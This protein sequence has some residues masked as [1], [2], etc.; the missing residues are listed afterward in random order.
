[1]V[2]SSLTFLCCALPLALAVY[3]LVP[4]RLKNGWLLL[5]SLAFYAWGEPLYVLLMLGSIAV[6]WALALRI[7]RTGGGK[8][9]FLMALAVVL[10]IGLLVVYK[11]SALLISSINAI[12]P[13]ALPVPQIRLPI[14]I[15]F[16]TF[17]ALSYVI[18]VYRGR[19]PVQPRI[20]KLALY[21]SLFPQLIAGP[22]VR[23][24][25]V[26]EQIDGRRESMEG[27][28]KGMRRFVTGLAKKVL[29]ANAVAPLADEAF[30]LSGGGLG[31]A[32]AWLGLLCYGM[33]IY[34]DFS[35]YSD[36]AIGLG[37]MFGFDFMEN[38]RH[39]YISAS[40]REFWTRWHISL[41]TWFRDYVYIPLGGNRVG[42]VRHLANI[43]VVFLLTGLWH[44]ANWNF[45]IWGAYHGAFRIAEEFVPIQRLPRPVRWLGALL[46]V[47]MGWVLF[48]TESVAQALGYF[49]ALAGTSAGVLLLTAATPRALLALAIG[50]VGCTP[51]PARWAAG[52]KS[53]RLEPVK[54]AFTLCLLCL[55]MLSL[56]SAA[57]NP[58][59]YFRF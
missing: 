42:K 31:A 27:F 38:F 52:L 48:R 36:M 2:F 54:W 50:I 16:F 56:A 10:D 22:I 19:V 1:M 13:L 39:P 28:E 34:F 32:G 33:Q 41:S 51:Y 37:H 47:L 30:L 3:Y 35:G 55:C 14:G 4:R 15:S 25:D 44:G 49:G 40:M 59:I 12:T 46:V 11:Y 18:D 21:I 23:Y 29:I 57:Y 5:F 58:F 6:N 24:A 9:R 45:L 7:H 17:Q 20:D 53:P 43:A 26:A 8:R